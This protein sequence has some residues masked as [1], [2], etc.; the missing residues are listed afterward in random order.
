MKSNLPCALLAGSHSGL[1]EGIR[2]LL[3][4][5]FEVVVTVNDATSLVETVGQL[6]PKIAIIDVNL[7][8]GDM[9]TLLQDLHFNCPTA[10]ILLLG[11]H[12]EAG[13]ME[14]LLDAGADSF[15]LKQAIATEILPAVERLLGGARNVS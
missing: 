2:L 10:R 12:N 13:F 4:T 3:A 5:M 9:G 6:N 8:R 7:V 15:V 14:S 11:C 1:S